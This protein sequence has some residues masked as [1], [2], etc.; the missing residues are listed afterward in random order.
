MTE[1][2]TNF[3]KEAFGTLCFLL[4]VG[5]I[6][7]YNSADNGSIGETGGGSA[8]LDMANLTM[9]EG[10]ISFRLANNS[11]RRDTIAFWLEDDRGDQICGRT[12]KWT[13]N[14]THD[15]NLFCQVLKMIPPGGYY[16]AKV[17][18]ATERDKQMFP[19]S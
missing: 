5:A 4:V 11:D 1:E 18:W 19:E 17:R 9:V 8:G 12:F 3:W 14:L 6:V 16:T 10:N 2:K 15:V 7:L 13:A